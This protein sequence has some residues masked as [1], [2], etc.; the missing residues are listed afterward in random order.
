M[1]APMVWIIIPAISGTILFFL[2]KFRNWMFPVAFFIIINLTL[3]ALV[4]PINDL[5]N[6][7]SST[8]ALQPSLAISEI[9]FV[10]SNSDRSFLFIINAITAFFLVGTTVAGIHRRVIPISFWLVA[11]IV[12]SFS[13]DPQITGILF[14]L[15]VILISALALSSPG[16]K[17]TGDIMRFLIYQLIGIAFVLF[18]GGMMANTP[19][20]LENNQGAMN[21]VMLLGIGFLFLFSVF[22]LYTWII[23]VAEET[24]PYTT[25]YVLLMLFGG[26]S[27]FL[28]SI[29][30]EYPWIIDYFDVIGSIRIVGVVMVISGGTW[31][32]YDDNLGRMMGFAVVIDVGYTLLAMV[33]DDSFVLGVGLISKAVSFI[34]WGL[35]LTVLKFGAKNLNFESVQGFIRKFP[36]ASASILFAHFSF[37]GFPLL[38]GFPFVLKLWN[39]LATISRLMS[40]L[41]LLGSAG[42][43]IGGIRSF[44]ELIMK[45]SDATSSEGEDLYQKI[46]LS[47]G[48]VLLFLFGLFP[49]WIYLW[50]T[51]FVTPV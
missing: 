21:I 18:A 22:P 42:L 4:I 51:T 29:L 43:M 1:N 46:F 15:P 31:A 41:C 33:N 17:V 45:S 12:A 44:T 7:G 34:V 26:Y 50:F 48:I 23:K 8:Y 2:Q 16:S 32:A 5:V 24:H 28:S 38:A 25:I 40:W 6:V 47:I 30:S 20:T 19:T 3:A 9:Q 36:Y 35:G 37:A 11:F 39:E 13:Y 27:L 10:L 14:F 49:N